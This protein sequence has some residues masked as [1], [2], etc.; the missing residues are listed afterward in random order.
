MINKILKRNIHNLEEQLQVNGSNK[1]VINKED[2]E[3]RM[4]SDNKTYCQMCMCK[5]ENATVDATVNFIL[6]KEQI[7]KLL[8]DDFVTVK[9]DENEIREKLTL[10]MHSSKERGVVSCLNS[11][12]FFLK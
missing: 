2:I 4:N 9:A 8:S 12:F 10:L 5:A 6:F 3:I 11:T 1:L 7:A